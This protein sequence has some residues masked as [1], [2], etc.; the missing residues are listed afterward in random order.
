M[1]D[2]I[3]IREEVQKAASLVTTARRLLATGTMV[4]LSA[5]ESRIRQ[6]C[7]GCEKIGI[8]TA[9]AF[10]PALEGL[11][12]DLDRLSLALT[13]HHEPVAARL[14]GTELDRA[15]SNSY[16]PPPQGLPKTDEII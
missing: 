13:E 1:S 10:R 6:I 4:D 12:A 5:L 3:D 2:D 15:G 9:R 11:I 16:D 14:G 7:N 8:E